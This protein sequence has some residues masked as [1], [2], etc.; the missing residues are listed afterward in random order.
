MA[1]LGAALGDSGLVR[2]HETVGPWLVTIMTDPTPLRS[3]PV[4]VSILLQE[5]G[6]DHIE[7]DATIALSL[8]HIA[9]G[10]HLELDATRSA[11][12]NQL[13]YAAKFELPEVGEWQVRT[14]IAT[15]AA[16][17]ALSW[18]FDAAPPLTS[19]D[20]AWPWMLPAPAAI[21]LYG[22]NRRLRRKKHA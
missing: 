14:K 10:L 22:A 19:W 17:S 8:D 4:D 11:A 20:Q 18:S 2:V 1:L 5:E 3:G 13:L 15:P 7:L 12:D 6:T 9:S 16:H 21:L